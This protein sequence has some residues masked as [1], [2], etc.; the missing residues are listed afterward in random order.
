M[1]VRPFRSPFKGVL[2]LLALGTF[3][4]A[5][6]L[7]AMEAAEARPAAPE[8]S[9]FDQV[10]ALFRVATAGQTTTA[11]V[12]ARKLRVAYGL[13]ETPEE[14]ALAA[15]LAHWAGP[16]SAR[17]G[18]V[19]DAFY[20]GYQELS[21]PAALIAMAQGRQTLQDFLSAFPDDPEAR[22]AHQAQNEER[23]MDLL[24]KARQAMDQLTQAL[25]APY[26]GAT[27][28]T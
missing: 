22:N 3:A 20:G 12:A 9:P 14:G 10:E 13:A 5:P 19:F 25:Q 26:R 4:P 6:C 15:A 8:A 27:E 23:A 16:G 18:A 7:Q 2:S 11:L 1:S 17:P 21:L 24:A 28:P